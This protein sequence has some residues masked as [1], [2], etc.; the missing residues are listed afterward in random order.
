MS[1]R[2]R[3]IK[4]VIEALDGY[5]VG[6]Y[7]SL[8]KV[9]RL[10]HELGLKLPYNWDDVKKDVEAI[11]ALPRTAPEYKRVEK[12]DRRV[13]LLT[14]LNLVLLL[15]A[16][17]LYALRAWHSS[18]VMDVAVL[19]LVVASLVIANIAYYIRAYI[20]VKI[21]ALYAERLPELEKLGYRIKAVV[22]YLLRQLRRE[23]RIAGVDPRGY[24]LKLWLP[25]YS[26][27][28]VVKKPSR[29]SSKFEVVVEPAG[30]G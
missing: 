12:M 8:D 25:D 22:E 26:G 6:R 9:E 2:A 27:V 19:V 3:K 18:Y 28:K 20:T 1:A 16:A 7:T 14:K 4:E 23:L 5:R 11:L 24:R 21:G 10:I 15:G 13:S 30:K 17:I 29:F